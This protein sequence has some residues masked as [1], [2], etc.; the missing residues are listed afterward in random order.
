ME[1]LSWCCRIRGQGA[2][3][4]GIHLQD[5]AA[6][7]HFRQGGESGLHRGPGA[8]LLQE[9]DPDRRGGG[10]QR[11]AVRGHDGAPVSRGE[12]ERQILPR[13]RQRD[14][15]QNMDLIGI[16]HDWTGNDITFFLNYRLLRTKMKRV[17][18]KEN[19]PIY[20]KSRS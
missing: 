14:G 15:N 1:W 19:L 8:T 16:F 17:A 18:K 20:K 10:P 4:E 13:Q 12:N 3:Q 5:T 7:A 9:G 6:T 11:E 2:G